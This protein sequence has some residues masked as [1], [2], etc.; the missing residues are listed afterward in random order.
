[1]EAKEYFTQEN[2]YDEDEYKQRK[3]SNSQNSKKKKSID[4]KILT[5]LQ[6]SNYKLK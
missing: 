1:M 4:T 6:A 3:K 2:Y 5:P